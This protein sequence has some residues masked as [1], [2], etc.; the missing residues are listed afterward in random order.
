MELPDAYEEIVLYVISHGCDIENPTYAVR[1]VIELNY[2][3]LYEAC[4]PIYVAHQ[5]HLCTSTLNPRKGFELVS[6]IF[7]LDESLEQQ[8][9]IYQEHYNQMVYHGELRDK[10]PNFL[11]ITRPGINHNYMFTTRA[12]YNPESTLKDLN[13]LGVHILKNTVSDE[14]GNLLTWK[15]SFSDIELYRKKYQEVGVEKESFQAFRDIDL[16]V[17]DEELLSVQLSRRVV[18]K[19]CNLFLSDIYE[20]VYEWYHFIKKGQLPLVITIIDTSCRSSCQTIKIPEEWRHLSPPLYR[21]PSYQATLE[22]PYFTNELPFFRE[23]NSFNYL[24]G[25]KRRSKK[26]KKMKGL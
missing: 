18:G 10:E 21:K 6:S 14:T 16:S 20:V 1:N 2:P 4:M 12:Y 17:E 23:D 13:W 26:N 9:Y 15:S 5:S 8:L 7:D 3:D 19:P 22:K 11:S 25:K 24:K